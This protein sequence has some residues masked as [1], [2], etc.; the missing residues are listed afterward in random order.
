M[1]RSVLRA[2]SSR[3]RTFFGRLRAFFDGRPGVVQ[4]HDGA[5][6]GDRQAEGYDQADVGFES[7]KPTTPN[8]AGEYR[9][10]QD[11]DQPYGQDS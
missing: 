6:Y 8:S 5:G 3:A 10:S 11:D 1:E 2:C 9:E 4:E 7:H